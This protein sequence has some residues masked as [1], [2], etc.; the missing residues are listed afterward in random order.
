MKKL[1]LLVLALLC[2][3]FS[4]AYSFYVGG[5]YYKVTSSPNSTVEVAPYGSISGNYSGAVSIP[6]YVTYNGITY[7]VTSVGEKAFKGCS[8]LTSVTI[9]KSVVSIGNDA[10]NGCSKLKEVYISDLSA[11][12]K[13][14]FS[15]TDSNPLHKKNA[16]LFLN[17]EK[18]KDLVI[19]EDVTSIGKFAFYGCFGLSSV[20]IPNSVTSIGNN[21]FSNC[22]GLTSV[23]LG[24][25]VRY[26][27]SEAFY[28]CSSL[29]SLE[30]PNSVININSKAFYGCSGLTSV[31]IGD[32]VMIMGAEAFYGLFKLEEVH[33]SDISAWC[34]IVFADYM[35]NPLTYGDLYID[36]E[37]TRDLV[38]PDGVVSIGAYAF[39]N[40]YELTTVTIPSSVVSIGSGAFYGCE[41]LQR[42]DVVAVNPPS[43]SDDTFDNRYAY[44]CLYV[45]SESLSAYENHSVWGKSTNIYS[46]NTTE[47]ENVYVE[48]AN[49][50]GT[51][52]YNLQGMKMQNADNLPRGIYINKG[53]KY[54]VK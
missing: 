34:K 10:F 9:P 43:V 21:A 47:I 14:D 37:E 52:V 31:T 41:N 38:I 42:I 23:S 27:D 2:S 24:D 22:S 6:E 50:Y 26:I 8:K 51:A 7:S 16:Y 5:I 25:G 20:T 53:K 28:F 12:C 40:S 54:W 44:I 32:G 36:G 29:T 19:P 17:G 30:I 46:H 49:A 1:R 11:W 39:F 18:I 33:V 3:A 45:P 35:A 48:D 13:I 15:E 4:S